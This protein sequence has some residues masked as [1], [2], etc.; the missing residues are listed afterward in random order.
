MSSGRRCVRVSVKTR[1]T[2]RAPAARPRVGPL[3][4]RRRRPFASRRCSPSTRDAST[5][6]SWIRAGCPEAPP[7]QRPIPS[8]P[9]SPCPAVAAD[10]VH[11]RLAR[12]PQRRNRAG[13]P[14]AHV[15]ALL[16]A[17]G[18]AQRLRLRQAARRPG[19]GSRGR[20]PAARRGLLERRSHPLHRVLRSRP[21]QARH[22]PEPA[23][24]PGAGRGEALYA[25]RPARLA[26]WT[27]PASEGGVPARRSPPRLRSSGRS[28]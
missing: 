17:D 5:R 9:S 15:S 4:R 27:R 22:P 2:A 7:P 14:A 24:G 18:L 19:R 21:R 8:S 16:G 11:H 3:R 28:R 23:D 20:V 12:L 13:E 1:R 26:R 10:T 25:G 6:W